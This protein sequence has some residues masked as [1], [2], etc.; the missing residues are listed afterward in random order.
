MKRGR[1]RPRLYPLYATEPENSE[2]SRSS[3][4]P[5][6]FRP[7]SNEPQ[8]FDLG[9]FV[10][11]KD[12]YFSGEPFPIYAITFGNMLKKYESLMRGGITL[13]ESSSKFLDKDMDSLQTSFFK[14][15]A[16]VHK[17]KNPDVVQ[18]NEI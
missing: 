1:G 17:G 12:N 16:S 5:Q 13:H 8:S 14:I 4:L 18:E 11:E 6:V 10:V 15:E 3:A 7:Y 2:S 9:D